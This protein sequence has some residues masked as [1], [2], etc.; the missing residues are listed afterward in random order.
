MQVDLSMTL[1]NIVTLV[2]LIGFFF[3][4]K[5][6]IDRLLQVVYASNGSVRLISFEAHDRMQEQCRNS[7]S[8]D[9]GY[10]RSDMLRIEGMLRLQNE[11]IVKLNSKIDDLGKC[12][13]ALKYG[14]DGKDLDVC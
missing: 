9:S 12:V 4:G 1:G 5:F 8:K 13:A 11:E 2:G 6:N 3:W 7:I 14:A 10:A